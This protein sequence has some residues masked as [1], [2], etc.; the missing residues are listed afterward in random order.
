MTD[1]RMDDT[2]EGPFGNEEQTASLRFN[3]CKQFKDE[4]ISSFLPRFQRLLARSPSSSGDDTHPMYQLGNSLNRIT[5]NYLVGRVQPN[6]FHKLLE[7]SYITG[8][9]IEEI[10][11]IKTKSY[12][13]N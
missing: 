2:T 11:L 3:A 1:I 6:L 8:A 9:Q 13:D 7:F 4:S 12:S 10:G 5:K